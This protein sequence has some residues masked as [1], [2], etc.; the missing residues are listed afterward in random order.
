MG[1]DDGDEMGI[2]VLDYIGDAPQSLDSGEVH[3][4]NIAFTFDA[5]KDSWKSSAKIYWTSNTTPAD[6]IGY[7]PYNS[8]IP[9]FR[10]LSFQI[11]R[12]QDNSALNGEMGGYEASDFL[13]SKSKK[14]MPTSNRVDLNLHH[15]MTCVRVTLLEGKGFSEGE[16]TSLEKMIVIPNIQQKVDIDIEN[17]TLSDSYG[18]TVSVIPYESNSDWRGVVIPQTIMVGKSIIDITIGKDSYHLIKN[19]SVTY[20]SGKLA[21]FTITVDKRSEGNF[22]FELTDESITPWIDDIDFREGIVRNY[23][24]LNII[25]RGTLKE[26]VEK[27]GLS[28]SSLTGLKLSGEM[29][30]EDFK[31]L[32]E[33][34]AALKN[35]N[36]SD[37]TVWS[38][39][40]KNVIPERAM[41]Q[42]KTL[43]R[44]IFPKTLEIIGSDAFYECGLMGSLVIPEGVTKIGEKE[45]WQDNTGYDNLNYGVF[46]QCCSLYGELSL[47][48]TL[49]FIEDN[50]FAKTGFT[51]TLNIPENVKT[52]GNH[53]F[54]GNQFSGDLIIPD[55]VE[56]IGS[57]AFSGIP[58]TGRLVL[59]KNIKT[60]YAMT[61]E[62]CGFSGVLSLPEGLRNIEVSAFA[63]CKIRGELK[64]PST[65]Q[66]ISNRAFERTKI[67]S[68][69]LPENLYYIGNADF[70]DCSEL[71]GSVTIPSKVQRVCQ[72]LFSGCINLN[73]VVLP[74]DVLTIGAAAFYKCVNLR[75]LVCE[76]TEPPMIERI[77]RLEYSDAGFINVQVGPFDGLS[78]AN[79]S[80]EVPKESVSLYKEAD[81]WNELIRISEY[82]GFICR[83]AIACALNTKHQETLILNSDGE[84]EVIEKPEWCSLSKSSGNMKT[85]IILTIND[86]P[87]GSDNREASV[88]FRLKGTDITSEC[89]VKQFDYQYAEDEC[90]TLQ[91]ATRGNGIDLLFL[92]DGWDA[93]SIANGAYLNKIYEQMEAFFGIEP[94][95]T[96]RDRFNV[97]V[98]MSLSQES[99]VN[100]AST[101][102][103]TRFSTFFSYDW[104]NRSSLFV[105]D[106]DM[107]FDYAVAHTPLTKDHMDKS[108]IIIS[109]NNNEYGS[110]TMLTEKGSAIAICCSDEENFP[111]DTRGI[112]QHEAC[113]H[114]FGKLAEERIIKNKYLPDGRYRDIQSYQAKGWYQNI[115]LTGKLTDVSWNNFIFDPRYS[116][117]VDLYEGAYE[118]SRGVYR[119]EIN[120]CMNYGI[121]YFS[122]PARLDIMRRILEYSGE[123]FTMEKFY[124]TDSDKWGSTGTTRAAIPDASYAYVNSGMHH[125]VRIVKSKK[126]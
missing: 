111:M 107:V 108:L 79:V 73:E 117:A 16:W 81:G 26:I 63:G 122:A 114:A 33:E 76:C 121:P 84:W 124:E 37:V 2:C 1:F 101:W 99:G 65:V 97:Y 59:P 87:K 66:R 120:S 40:R 9:S 31:F 112:I 42:K 23:I 106:V 115:S 39:N 88:V 45:F 48:S 12:R 54:I 51:G 80:L 32:R 18:E 58:F 15:L 50:A 11:H 64:L 30:E 82:S 8:E 96:Y 123:G 83:P 109:L 105:D 56:N 57:A 125:P 14:V 27:S 21:S 98:A 44:I 91:N 47:P 29:D 92:G 67:S 62:G 95:S 75:R 34:C 6:I 86:L 69:V 35:L 4:E 49:Q 100:T 89:I 17:G 43:S 93:A 19:S 78:K 61:F 28:P 70:E 113:G 13:W 119:A 102:F 10:K 55:G 71:R 103:N 20:E 118:Y 126:Y 5:S 53:A 85:E 94:F 52:I 68:L 7:Y 3:A 22:Q 104:N 60:I 36:L 24:N 116:D 74:K 90:V 25:K 110:A 46:A 41:Y 77:N 72:D 38:G